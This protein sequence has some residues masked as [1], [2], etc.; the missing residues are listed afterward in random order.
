MKKRIIINRHQNSLG[1]KKIFNNKVVLFSYNWDQ[2][3]NLLFLIYRTRGSI[4]EKNLSKEL[5]SLNEF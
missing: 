2:E 3:N 1:V 5:S 4:L